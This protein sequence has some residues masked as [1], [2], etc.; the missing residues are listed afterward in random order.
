VT[1]DAELELLR[2]RVAHLESLVERLTTTQVP[3]IP[4]GATAPR[5]DSSTLTSEAG[6][7]RRR[8][9]RNGL[10]LSAA[11]VTGVGLVDA[12]GSAAAASDGDAVT[13][14]AT[15]SPTSAA[16]APTR[17]LN[18]SASTH[19][20]VLF[21][22][23]NSTD[24]PP[25]PPAGSKAAIVATY[26]GADD[27]GPTDGAAIRALTQAHVGVHGY[28]EGSTGVRGESFGAEGVHGISN[29]GAG[30]SAV[31]ATGPGLTA[32]SDSGRGIEATTTTGEAIRATSTGNIAIVGNATADFGVVGNSTTGTGVG[33]TG[34]TGVLTH[35]DTIGV[36]SSSADGIGVRATAT[37]GT[38]IEATSDSGVG[39]VARS[40][41]GT[42]LDVRSEA[43]IG[44]TFW[45]G[46]AAIRLAPR[47][48]AGHPTSG[49][50]RRGE[51][52]VDSRGRLWLCT[53]GGSPGT[54]KQLAFV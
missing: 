16:S 45:G 20:P 12:A 19:S 28:S 53:K 33:A 17:I 4:A 15:R 14:A 5:R 41:D 13:I 9:L 39:I 46:A 18:P 30:V 3:S 23:D 35:G 47:A 6:F 22:V 36:D 50:H 40:T 52:V 25:T 38:G 7:D 48:T 43:G 51:L 42:G 37:S 27:A 34:V 31:S 54:W 44:G 26:S 29:V 21:Q 8:V 1:N 24:S 11:A 2:A 32:T 10:G 49:A